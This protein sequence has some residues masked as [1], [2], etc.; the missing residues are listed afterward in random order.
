MEEAGAATVA[1]LDPAVLRQLAP[2]L[3]AV[4]PT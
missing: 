2:K 1:D 4:P 3:W